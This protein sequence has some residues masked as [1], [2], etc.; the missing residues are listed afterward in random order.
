MFIDY[1]IYNDRFVDCGRV[2]GD[3]AACASVSLFIGTRCAGLSAAIPRGELLLARPF[4]AADHVRVTLVHRF[5]GAL[6]ARPNHVLAHPI[7]VKEAEATEHLGSLDERL[8]RLALEFRIFI[9]ELT[10]LLSFQLGD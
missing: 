1:T 7:G 10:F 8:G 5:D 4:L 3:A 6:G 9:R 2:H